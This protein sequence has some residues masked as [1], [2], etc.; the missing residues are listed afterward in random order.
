[1]SLFGVDFGSDSRHTVS[2]RRIIAKSDGTT[3]LKHTGRVYFAA[4][5]IL[6]HTRGQIVR[7]FKLTPEQ[8]ESLDKDYL[9]S[10]LAHDLGKANSEFILFC[11]KQIERQNVRHE[12]ISAFIV[13]NYLKEWL[14]GSGIN[15]YVVMSV[16]LGHH[17]KAP[18]ESTEDYP[19]FGEMRSD[20]R[21]CEIYLDSLDINKIIK[22]IGRE[23]GTDNYPTFRDVKFERF[24]SSS[25]E[26]ET[27]KLDKRYIFALKVLLIWADTLGSVEFQEGNSIRLWVEDNLGPKPNNFDEFLRSIRDVRGIKKLNGMQLSAARFSKTTSRLAII[28]NCGSGK[29]YAELSY[30]KRFIEEFGYD[31][32]VHITPTKS[33]VDE[34]YAKYFIYSKNANIFHSQRLYSLK[35]LNIDLEEVK[36]FGDI[37]Y[38]LNRIYNAMTPDQILTSMVYNRKGILLLMVLLNSVVVFDEINAYDK[39]MLRFFRDFCD[40]FD[41][42]IITMSATASPN[43]LNI[44]TDCSFRIFPNPERTFAKNFRKDRYNLNYLKNMSFNSMQDILKKDF[45]IALVAV[46]TVNRCRKLAFK[47]KKCGYNVIC[48]HSRYKFSDRIS[49][50]KKITEEKHDKVIIVATQVLEIGIDISAD[51]FISEIAPMS[52]IIQRLGRVNR[53]QGSDRID[54]CY[55]YYPKDIRPYSKED[56]IYTEDILDKISGNASYYTLSSCL[57]NQPQKPIDSD[58]V[59]AFNNN[60]LFTFRNE[61]L[62]EDS[63]LSVNCIIEDDY[64]EVISLLKNKKPIDEFLVPILEP[65][66]DRCAYFSPN[67][68][69]KKYRIIREEYYDDYGFDNGSTSECFFQ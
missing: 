14:E 23:V 10:A 53:K 35:T 49:L 15:P 13:Y 66:A 3:L 43:V 65:D 33:L 26:L 17:L 1:M 21:E 24:D 45:K 7:L 5:Q 61:S 2:V 22:F 64:D 28:S 58:K 30:V 18:E 34:V 4:K 8:E 44:L 36:D 52:S 20:E 68:E 25:I 51:L 67:K 31:R 29:T 27:D 39:N 50:Y 19:K 54:N 16:I 56:L 57:E 47:L 11:D 32:V 48:Y 55:F 40:N 62:R 59:Y 42:P 41:V 37:L 69:L 46:N 63:V 6:K 12:H 9:I 60:V 38:N